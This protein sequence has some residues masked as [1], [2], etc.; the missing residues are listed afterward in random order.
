MC[1][2]PSPRSAGRPSGARID[3]ALLRSQRERLGLSRDD[4]AELVGTT[5][6][7]LQRVENEGAVSL[8]LLRQLCEALRLPVVAVLRADSE[9][10]RASLREYGFG[11]GLPP[12]IVG[13]DNELSALRAR[14]TRPGE[15]TVLVLDGPIG[16]GKT[17]LAQHLAHDTADIF[18]DGVVWVRGELGD[19][20]LVQRDIARAL[21]FEARLPPLGETSGR[22]WKQSFTAHFW[23]GR[24]LLIIDD[25][26]DTAHVEA[27]LSD[28]LPCSVLVTTRF[29]H[30]AE[31]V[32]TNRMNIR[33]LP[34]DAIQN[35]LADGL[36]RTQLDADPTSLARL[37]ALIDG[38]PGLARLVHTALRRERLTTPKTWLTRF[39][40]GPRAESPDAPI[41]AYYDS[42][43][44]QVSPEAWDL[45]ATL[46]LFES[47]PVPLSWAEAAS[48]MEPGTSHKAASEL[49]DAQ[50]VDLYQAA[51]EHA[52][53]D[54]EPWL[55]L[56][57]HPAAAAR[58]LLGEGAA[59]AR[60]R[61]VACLLKG[62][63]EVRAQPTPSLARYYRRHRGLF[64]LIQQ[65]LT[66]GLGPAPQ[67]I[68]LDD[69]RK[70]EALPPEA[71]DPIRGRELIDLITQIAPLLGDHTIADSGEWLG[72]GL[73]AARSLADA[74]RLGR[75][76]LFCGWWRMVHRGIEVQLA[77]QE[78]ALE[79]FRAAQR[80][81]AVL[82][83]HAI[84]TVL[85]AVVGDTELRRE[86]LRMAIADVDL[87]PQPGATRS[88]ILSHITRIALSA[89]PHE[90]TREAAIVSRQALDELLTTSDPN[91]LLLETLRA[92][93]YTL[94]RGSPEGDDA[95]LVASLMELRRLRPEPWLKAAVLA[96]GACGGASMGFATPDL[97]LAAARRELWECTRDCPA[98]MAP[99][100]LWFVATAGLYETV[101]RSGPGAPPIVRAGLGG[102]GVPA[103]EGIPVM[104]EMCGTEVLML[105]S[106]R[107]TGALLD[108]DYIE[109]ALEL[110]DHVV[111]GRLVSPALRGLRDLL[112]RG[113]VAGAGSSET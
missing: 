16:V 30:I 28:D 96:H 70:V 109:L 10:T 33:R 76:Y 61:L 40:R 1:P 8:P 13:R 99:R 104:P 71:F 107:A 5:T 75:M 64:S 110:A 45:F 72:H 49:L 103:A 86:A 80:P 36:D 27:F 4:L 69:P 42:L 31:E 2:A 9:A 48:G 52:S 95:A 35:I 17:S 29:V 19:V 41:L 46:G 23:R 89:T 21:G 100:L 85:A 12:S 97:A 24:R 60:S 92:N 57:T 51:R 111:D 101:V 94:L 113:E 90:P 38:M 18:E 82:A 112:S 102:H 63:A 56:A 88:S 14:L 83:T 43:R 67:L 6:R 55:R 65:V 3:G 39:E 78:A 25:A 50:I 53:E 106:T 93:H 22:D 20:R 91:S 34:D 73:V 62:L 87:D 59:A 15:R 11:P 68:A 58:T 105:L 74:E 7:T 47:E 54:A 81:L 26:T 44:T 77:Y 84:L 79:A 108:L 66:A 32:A 98:E 37:L